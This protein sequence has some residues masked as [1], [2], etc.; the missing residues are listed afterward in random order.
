MI[1]VQSGPTERGHLS[2]EQRSDAELVAMALHDPAS[3]SLIFRKYAAPVH[4]YCDRCLGTREAAEDAAQTVFLKAFASLKTCRDPENLRSWLFSIAHN[5]IID[6]RRRRRPEN[7]IDVVEDLVDATPS[8]EEIAISSAERLHVT[9]L[10]GQLP[11]LQREVV[12]L[13]LQGMTDKEIAGLLGKSHQAI[14]AAQHRALVQL[15]TL[16]H[17]DLQ[18]GGGHAMA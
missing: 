16:I 6:A 2:S 12:E 9:R 11:S 13:R 10:L 17:A 14:R 5:V 18:K 7:S 4:Q 8:P 3:F 15:R 1:A